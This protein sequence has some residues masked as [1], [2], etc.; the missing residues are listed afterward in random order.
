MNGLNSDPA[1]VRAAFGSPAPFFCFTLDTEPDDLWEPRPELGFTHF[2]RLEAFHAELTK[3]GAR[4]TYLT[5][6]E[7]AEHTGAA[8][9]MERILSKGDCEIGAH[10]HTW[11][12][13]WPFDVPDL[14]SPPVPACVHRLGQH[15]EEQ[16][17]D[18]T[19]AALYQRLGVRP[20]S[21]RGGRWSFNDE[22]PVSLRNCGIQV[23]STLTPGISWSDPTD[24]LRSGPDFRRAERYPHWLGEDLLELPVGTSFHPNPGRALDDSLP[25]RVLRLIRRRAGLPAGVQWLRPTQMTRTQLRQCLNQLQQAQVPI[26]VAMIHSSEIG[27]NRY[28][29]TEDRVAAFR[30]RCLELVQDA[31]SMGAVGA[32]LAE[33]RACA[34]PAA[35]R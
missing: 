30:Q 27:I 13:S 21:Y 2:D 25:S 3:A 14:G 26:W 5:T 24:E 1:A 22:T 10:F 23:D 12:R 29:P 4:P 18:Y 34:H 15:V 33:V 28:F 20:V 19:C 16:M 35:A 7:V 11:T 31:I 8:K 9:V 32:T 17:L 6:S